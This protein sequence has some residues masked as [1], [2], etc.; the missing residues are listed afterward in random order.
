MPPPNKRNRLVAYYDGDTDTSRPPKSPRL[1]SQPSSSSASRS[2]TQVPSSSYNP[3]RNAWQYGLEDEPEI[4]DLT[5]ADEGPAPE[6]YG[7]L[8]T[9]I[10]GVRYYNGVASPGEVVICKREPSN[11]VRRNLIRASED[12]TTNITFSTT[13]MPFGSTTCLAPKLDTFPEQWHRNCSHILYVPTCQSTTKL[14]LT[15][16]RTTMISHL[17]PFSQARKANLIA[18]SDSS[19]TGLVVPWREHS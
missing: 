13:P 17:K 18:L 2:S 3:N 5:Q 10:V 14:V 15:P 16:H 4:I 19:S 1:S 7:T 8:D 11:P 6:L 12:T 9:K